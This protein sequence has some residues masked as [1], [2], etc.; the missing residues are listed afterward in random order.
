MVNFQKPPKIKR[1]LVYNPFEELGKVP[2]AAVEQVSGVRAQEIASPSDDAQ[3]RNDV[4]PEEIVEAKARAR[5]GQL[6][7]EISKVREKKRQDEMGKTQEATVL[8]K[9][10]KA[11]IPVGPPVEPQGKRRRGV[12]AG[13]MGLLQR[14]KKG[15]ELGKAPVQ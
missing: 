4:V 11:Q 3:D 1:P 13:M 14:K 12:L 2:R 15:V 6:R 9:Q 8:E 5:L 7:A 10:E